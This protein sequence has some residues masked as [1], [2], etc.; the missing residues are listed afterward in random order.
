MMKAIKGSNEEDADPIDTR[1]GVVPT[2]LI[3]YFLVADHRPG[4]GP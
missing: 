2:G 1:T 3:D 4:M